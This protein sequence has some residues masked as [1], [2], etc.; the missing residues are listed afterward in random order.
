MRDDGGF[1]WRPIEPADA[2]AW[3][4]LVAAI[5]ATDRDWHYFTEQDLL[6]TFGD[7]NRDFPRGSVSVYDGATMVGYDVLIT[8]NQADPVPEIHHQGGVH[9]AYRRRG[10]GNRL[11]EWAETTAV[12][13]HGSRVD[14]PLS[15]SGSCL[16]HNSGALALYA[17]RGYRAAR[18]FHAMV[19]ELDPATPGLPA[20]AGV[21]IV[22]CTPDR[23]EDAR[24]IRNE[25]FR[26][27]WGSAE[28]SVEDWQHFMNLGA[29]R[30][31]FSFLAYGD[32]EPLGMVIGHEY[33]AYAEATGV[34]DVYIPIVGTRR[35]GRGRGIASALLSRALTEAR[36]A[37][38]TNA[39]L[40]VDADSPTGA[41]GLY[42]RAGFTVEHTAIT[43]LKQL[44][45]AVD[46]P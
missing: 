22:P 44:P 10:L 43:Q 15:L 39:S 45:E 23:F 21:D 25:A 40:N 5:Q 12:A 34:R 42:E 13:L 31:Q 20:P 26:D 35:A 17:A 14:G 32:G 1:E 38:F 19:A 9:P 6:E 46:E 27:H 4:T 18:W 7:P 8:K 28:R 37:G 41:L 30:P 36:A 3:A 2:G 33:D 16:S 24:L 29:F 11:L